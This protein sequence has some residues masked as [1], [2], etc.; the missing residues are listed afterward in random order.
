MTILSS[1]PIALSNFASAQLAAAWMY[2]TTKTLDLDVL[3]SLIGE[4]YD[5]QK[6]QHSHRHSGKSKDDDKADEAMAINS[7]SSKGKD[8]KG[9]TKK[10]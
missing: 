7:S 6:I 10:P 3:I 4:E 2:S 9:G 5:R 8:G 1:L